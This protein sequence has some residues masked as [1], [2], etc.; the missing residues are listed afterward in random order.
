[1]KPPIEFRP[2]GK[3]SKPAKPPDKPGGRWVWV[4]DGKAVTFRDDETRRGYMRDYMRERRKK[5]K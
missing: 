4:P 1:M 5:E 2:K 3:A